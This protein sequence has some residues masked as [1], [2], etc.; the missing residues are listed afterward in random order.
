[1]ISDTIAGSRYLQILVFVA[2]GREACGTA[3]KTSICAPRHSMKWIIHQFQVL[4]VRKTGRTLSLSTSLTEHVMMALPRL[5]L[6]NHDKSLLRAELHSNP[7]RRYTLATGRG[8]LLIPK[9]ACP[10]GGFVPH[11]FSSWAIT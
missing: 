7:I 8:S 4:F 1:M 5:E 9:G 2:L 10:I 3:G 6:G 11:T